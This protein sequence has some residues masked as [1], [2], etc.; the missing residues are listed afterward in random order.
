MSQKLNNKQSILE[1]TKRLEGLTALLDQLSNILLMHT[2][3]LEKIEKKVN[4]TDS[5]VTNS[6]YKIQNLDNQ[7]MHQ[8]HLCDI[9]PHTSMPHKLD[10]QILELNR[11]YEQLYSKFDIFEHTVKEQLSHALFLNPEN[12]S[13]TK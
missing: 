2:L 3:E 1:V 4:L 5:R 11:R 9:K 12:K 10:N 13:S 8:Q 7:V 6:E